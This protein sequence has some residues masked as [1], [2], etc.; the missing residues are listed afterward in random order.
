NPDSSNPR[1]NSV[2]S[3]SLGVASLP[4]NISGSLIKL[5]RGCK[6]GGSFGRRSILEHTSLN[7][8][9]YLS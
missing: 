1:A 4:R 6:I 2:S 5:I 8:Y 7:I 9:M 3:S